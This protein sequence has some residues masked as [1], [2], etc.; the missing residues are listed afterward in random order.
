MI[1]LTLAEADLYLGDTIRSSSRAGRSRIDIITVVDDL[2][3]SWPAEVRPAAASVDNLLCFYGSKPLVMPAPPRPAKGRKP[4]TDVPD[5]SEAALAEYLAKTD[6]CHR[7]RWSAA[8]N[9]GGW[10]G[11]IDTHW[12]ATHDR[13][14]LPL[15]VAVRRALADGIEARAFDAKSASRLESAGAIRGVGS[16]LSSWPSMRMPDE[17]DPP[18]LIACPRGVLDLNTGEWLPHDPIR[19]ITKCCPVD[20]GPTCPAWDSIENH[21]ADCLGD[22]YPAVHR[23]LGSSLLGLGADRRM[24]WLTGP[25][26]DGK[27][28]LAKALC[29]ALGPHA[30]T[31][32]A[33]SFSADGRSGSH[34]HE[35][36]SSMVGS[37]LAV[38]L[39]VSPRLNWRFVNGLSGGDKQTTKRSCG[40]AFSYDRTP[41]LALISNDLPSPP[42][43]ASAERVILARLR[44]PDD[45]DERIVATL[46]T[47]GP[48]RDEIASACLSWLTRGC[49]DFLAN[50]RSIGPVPM[51][52]F[53]PTGLDRWWAEGVASG[54][55][56]AGGKPCTTLG[57]IR[58]D[59]IAAGVEPPERDNELSAFLKSV[60]EFKRTDAGRFYAVG[61][62]ADDACFKTLHTRIGGLKEASLGVMIQECDLAEV[63][64]MSEPTVIMGGDP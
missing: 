16:L 44:P 5:G 43:R 23:F 39:E 42:D 9:Y 22:L 30:S 35:L 25:G 26:G 10:H 36:L 59:M 13:V 19:P 24:L 3:C 58:Q 50:G 17:I 21:L 53:Q 11:W 33:S 2:L 46:K 47:P 41:C 12:Q 20:P 34:E 45:Q 4:D 60:V 8:T 63:G 29:C 1:P 56:V 6:L 38:S 32:N 18:G 64:A 28:T 15:Q 49:A 54:R 52:A 37:R 27:S 55:L 51:I 40:K 57:Q 14:P 48:E 7:L 62:T 31:P 61:M